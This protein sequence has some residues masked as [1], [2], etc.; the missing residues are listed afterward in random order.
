MWTRKD[1]G[2]EVRLADFRPAPGDQLGDIRILGYIEFVR[3]TWESGIF[4]ANERLF[5]R[6]QVKICV[7]K[8]VGVAIIK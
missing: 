4:C 2:N 8:P 6:A 3:Q 1:Y 5:H 7:D